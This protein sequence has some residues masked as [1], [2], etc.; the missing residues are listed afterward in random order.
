MDLKCVWGMALFGISAILHCP[1]MA[2]IAELRV[3]V[4]EFDERRLNLVPAVRFA[5]ENS[6]GL[7]GEVLFEESDLLRWAL[8]PQVYIGG[9]VN[10]EGETSFAGAG[11]LWRQSLGEKFYGDLGV[12]LV[13]HNGTLDVT[14]RPGES[15][16]DAFNR[17]SQEIEFGSRILFREQMAIGYNVNENWSTELFYEHLSNA[18]L[19]KENDG[20]NNLGIRAVKKF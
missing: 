19:A 11:L 20:V 18:G 9:T 16:S 4:T 13:V 1:A 7:N 17:L 5:D 8:S 12:G 10:L 14:L 3:G 15:F 2:Q 6:V